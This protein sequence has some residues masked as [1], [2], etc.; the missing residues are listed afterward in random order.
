MLKCW[1][2]DVHAE[3]A[4]Q[5]TMNLSRTKH[6]HEE[7]TKSKIVISVNKIRILNIPKL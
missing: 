4:N 7:C 3:V 1:T 6:L 2:V 5:S